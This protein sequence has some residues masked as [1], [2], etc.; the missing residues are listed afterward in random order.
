MEQRIF[1]LLIQR[2]H[3]HTKPFAYQCVGNALD[4]DESFTI[5]QQKAIPTIIVTTLMNKPPS[6]TILRIVHDWQTITQGLA[7]IASVW[8]RRRFAP[9]DPG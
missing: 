6:A 1:Q 5:V 8:K 3:R 4:A 2:Q 7:H 9:S